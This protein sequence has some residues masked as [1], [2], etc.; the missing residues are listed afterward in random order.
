STMDM[1]ATA[2]TTDA[3][4]T[5][6][7]SAGPRQVVQHGD[8]TFTLL[9]TAHVSRASAEEVRAE[10]ESG[11][12]D[13]VAIELWDA[14]HAAL[15]E[16]EEMEQMDLFQVMRQGKIVMVAANLALGAYQ[17]RLAEQFGIEP[18]A[19]M[20][21]AIDA[22]D[23]ADLPLTLVDRNIGITLKRVYRRIPW[24]QRFTMLGGLFASMLSSDKIEEE[25]IEKLKQGDVLEATFKE[26]AASSATLHESLIDERDRFM[27]ARLL[28]T[29]PGGHVL[30]V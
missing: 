18:G 9:G 5:A 28:Q 2:A 14:G 7:D 1:S 21:A 24:W 17:Q 6:E 15:T 25:D 13:A 16:R 11:Q 23:A 10:I 12:Y 19:E 3:S 4:A 20:R 26:F 29:A 30:V 22:S 8:T 27:A